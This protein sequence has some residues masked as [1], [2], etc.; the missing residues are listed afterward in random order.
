MFRYLEA[1]REAGK[2]A[3]ARG[4]EVMDTGE[5]TLQANAAAIGKM[6]LLEALGELDFEELADGLR[7][8][9]EAK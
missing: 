3:W 9:G 8:H 5:M 2:E 4:S 6:K 7:Y 1:L